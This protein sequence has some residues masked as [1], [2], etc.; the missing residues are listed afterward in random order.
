MTDLRE[1][2]A[3]VHRESGIVLREPQHEAL[4]A[5]ADRAGAS[6]TPHTFL[7][8]LVDE[9]TVKET[10]FL[11]EMQQLSEIDWYEML[12][13]ARRAG[14]ERIRIWSA[15]CATG[16]EPYTLA[17]LATQAFGEPA[18]VTIL[19]TD[20]SARAVESARRGSYRP[21]STRE[22]DSSTRQRHFVDARDELAVAER[23]RALVTFAQ[24]NLVRDPCPPLGEPTFDLVL[25][26]NV[27]IYFDGETVDRVVAS[28]ERSL[29]PEGELLLGAADTLCRGA[30]RLRVPKPVKAVKPVP[31]RSAP[32]KP[33]PAVASIPEPL[34][35][36]PHFLDGL[37]HLEAGNPAAAIDAL[38][39]ALYFAP[40]LAAAAF[41]LGRAYE[42]A[43]DPGA[44]R[45]AYAQVLRTLEAEEGV[46]EP[47][48]DQV[49]VADIAAAAQARLGSL[50]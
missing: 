15:G 10:Y 37:A 13:R 21:R 16:E 33:A 49:E 28:L 38:R 22:L 12:A 26:R 39:R 17:L 36:E 40:R 24:H 30:G 35:S 2:A 20:I 25:C 4:Q 6:G 11:R 48:L 3:F 46:N 47:L 14:R 45:R 41:Q 42:L 27:L 8:R 29:A 50:A 32:R 44:A 31:R 19:G 9:V 34:P 7:Q 5:A 23:L 18:P 43:G 1:L